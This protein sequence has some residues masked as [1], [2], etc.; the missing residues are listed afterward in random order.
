MNTNIVNTWS[1]GLTDSLAVVPGLSICVLILLF[2]S[3]K[4]RTDKKCVFHVVCIRYN[5]IVK[6]RGCKFSLFK[7]NFYGPITFLS[8]HQL[9]HLPWNVYVNSTL[10]HRVLWDN[11][12]K[13][14]RILLNNTKDCVMVIAIYSTKY[15]L[16]IYSYQIG[17]LYLSV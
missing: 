4:A 10:Q 17:F 8:H 9:S 7:I 15:V 6:K 1:F 11:A 5:V 16:S 14:F 13:L 3:G 12:Y 2:L